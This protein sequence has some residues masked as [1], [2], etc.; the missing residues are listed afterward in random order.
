MPPSIVVVIRAD[1]LKTHRPVE[2]LRIALGL[3]VGENRLTVVLLDGAPLLL[4]EDTSDLLDAEVLEKY[5]PS[6]K[7][8][9]TPFV[10]PAGARGEFALDPGFDVRESSHDEIATLISSADRVLAF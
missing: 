6:L 5:L 9:K 4:T 7:Q 8:L 10:V 2:A 1:P 3:G